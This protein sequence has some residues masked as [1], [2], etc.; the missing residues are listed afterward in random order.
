[1]GGLP[2]DR[3]SQEPYFTYCGIN[4]FEPFLVKDGDEQRKYYGALFTCM[5]SRAV[6]IETAN[7]MSIDSFMLVLRIISYRGNVGMVCTI[8]EPILLG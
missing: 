7:N 4:M 3:L 6:H 5:S 8:M 2:S 1:M